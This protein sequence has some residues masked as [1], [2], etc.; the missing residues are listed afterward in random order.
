MMGFLEPQR[1][2]ARKMQL[3]G[4]SHF[5]NEDA[6]AQSICKTCSRQ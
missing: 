5:M 2:S 3:D 1:N 6:E 4:Y